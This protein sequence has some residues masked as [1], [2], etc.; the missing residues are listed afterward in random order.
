MSLPG[1]ARCTVRNW[2]SRTDKETKDRQRREAFDLWLACHTQD[3]I[4]ERLEIDQA[5]AARMDFMQIGKDSDL[6]ETSALYAGESWH[7]Y[8]VW[9]K[10]DK[11][12]PVSHGGN[13][14]RAGGSG[15]AAIEVGGA[16][17]RGAV[18]GAARGPGPPK[19]SIG[20]PRMTRAYPSRS[21]RSGQPGLRQ[22]PPRG[23]AATPL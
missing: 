11:S 23:G 20:G 17:K 16:A 4:A 14:R 13:T 7:P 15:G 1:P 19:R 8:N 6:H 22:L 21:P 12:N 2:L 9:K 3:E 10:Q 18:G 5:T